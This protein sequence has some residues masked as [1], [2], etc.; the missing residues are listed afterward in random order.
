M[1][2]LCL[3]RLEERIV[4]DGD[5]IMTPPPLPPEAFQAT[6]NMGTL[7]LTGTD[8]EEDVKIER[9]VD[10]AGDNILVWN[11]GVLKATVPTSSVNFINASLKGGN[12]KF[13]CENIHTAAYQG[14]WVNGDGGADQLTSE[15]AATLDGGDGND[16]INGS[17]GAD[18]IWGSN[19]NDVITANGGADIISGGADND[20]I[21]AGD[22]NDS[23]WGD[24]GDDTISGGLGQD[25]I[26]GG[27]GNDVLSGNYLPTET[28]GRSTVK[29]R[30][31]K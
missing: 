30:T 28:G 22:G 18:V 20:V 17:G 23:V 6:L 1:N 16:T 24:A 14:M 7:T 21:K 10:F 8:G 4:P 13:L 9:E 15:E 19:G 29:G 27:T 2:K 11:N 5:P 3:E 12:D 25:T 31:T 26:Y